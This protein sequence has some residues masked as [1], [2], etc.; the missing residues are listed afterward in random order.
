MA[1]SAF[2]RNLASPVRRLAVLAAVLSLAILFNSVLYGEGLGKKRAPVDLAYAIVQVAKQ[3]IPA[4]V[5]IDVIER[6]EV[7]NPFSPFEDDP[8]FRHFFG[9]NERGPRKFQRELRGLGTGMII[10]SSGYILTNHHVAGGATKI[11]VS[12]SDGRKFPAKLVG[13]DPRTDLAVVRIF[14][15]ESLPHITFGDSDK[16]EVGDWVIAIG[17][18]RGLDQTVTQGIVSAK[19]RRGITDPTSYQ[20]FLQTD[21]AINPGNSGGPLLN[22]YGEVIGVNTAIASQSGGSEGIGFAI[23]SKMAMEVSRTII[24]KGKVE[25]GW[26][27]LGVQDLT[28]DLAK[29]LGAAVNRGAVVESVVKGGPADQAGLRKGDIVVSFQGTEISDGAGLRNMAALA[30]IGQE[31]RLGVFRQ[32][33]RLD[34]NV[35]VGNL[36]EAARRIGEAA[37]ERLGVEA[38][39]ATARETERFGLDA[40]QGVIVTWVDPKG[41][42]GAVGFEAGDMILAI[43]DQAISGIETFIEVVGSLRPKQQVTILALDKRTGNRG[44]VQVVAR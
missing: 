32:G 5:H 25:R 11:E 28:P 42:L 27:G 43:N 3:N 37:K 1:G 10:D 20:D 2:S 36:E 41:P 40:K 39:A 33:K 23:P 12:L 38:R 14:T 7:A 21:A 6:R 29:S 15:K 26:L 8:F 35:K 24:V 18:P 34:L 16:M 17:H 9:N 30:P 22:L 19:H 13:S 44:T 31:V 4:V